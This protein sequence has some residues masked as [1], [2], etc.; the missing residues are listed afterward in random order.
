MQEAINHGIRT[1]V[2]LYT[3][4]M[5]EET[6]RE[7]ARFV[8]DKVKDYPLSYPIAYDVESQYLLDRKSV[9]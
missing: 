6:A 2:F 4:A 7:E 8:L 1:G 5:D 3:Q 9:V